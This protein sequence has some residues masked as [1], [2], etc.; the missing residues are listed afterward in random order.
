[1]KRSERNSK[2]AALIA[3]HRHIDIDMHTPT[4]N[5]FYSGPAQ[6]F[7]S[8]PLPLPDHRRGPRWPNR[9]AKRAEVV[10]YFVDYTVSESGQP[11]G[12]SLTF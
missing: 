7:L 10:L 1:M 12:E 2:S 3:P 5:P 8:L 6:A 4:P 11:A 9:D